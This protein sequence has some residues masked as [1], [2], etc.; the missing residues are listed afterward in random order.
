[1]LSR[2]SASTCVSTPAGHSSRLSTWV[3]AL[4]LPNYQKNA[5]F[6]WKSRQTRAC[7]R[8]AEQPS[9]CSRFLGH[10]AYNRLFCRTATASFF[11]SSGGFRE[12]WTVKD[13]LSS[14]ERPQRV[15]ELHKRGDSL[16]TGLC[17]KLSNQAESRSCF[18]EVYR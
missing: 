3:Y 17:Q 14:F 10:H 9:D 1:M 15:T 4:R 8:V 13:S 16:P 12:G 2:G 7:D 11:C 5:S 6:V 18:I